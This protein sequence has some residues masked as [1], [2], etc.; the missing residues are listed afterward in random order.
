MNEDPEY[1]TWVE[2]TPEDAVAA[3]FQPGIY[4]LWSEWSFHAHG[5]RLL[6]EPNGSWT[7]RLPKS[8]WT[9]TELR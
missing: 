5:W 2:P 1:L 9:E 8:Q 7:M 4:W 3:L 6:V